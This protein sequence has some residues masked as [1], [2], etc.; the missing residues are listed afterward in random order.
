GVNT[1]RSYALTKTRPGQGGINRS[2]SGPIS[3]TLHQA[4]D[5]AIENN[6]APLLAR[7]RRE[8]SRGQLQESLSGLLPNISATSSQLN[9]TRNLAALGIP[10]LPGRSSFVGPFDSFDARFQISQTLF[11]LSAVRQFQA[12]R[13]DVK[14]SD[15][16]EQ[17]A[18]EQ[19]ATSTS[20]AYL[21]SVRADKAVDAAQ[22]NLE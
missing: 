11:D 2:I 17:L 10:T 12:G 21:N 15:L 5:L 9:M 16:Q 7:E 14:I 18:F 8:E 19:I 13:S 22:A 6:L 4:I 20:L 3:L 1:P